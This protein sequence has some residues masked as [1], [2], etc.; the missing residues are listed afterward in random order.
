MIR[1]INSADWPTF[2]QRLS[3]ERAGAV[4]KLE[5]IEPGGAKSERA[6]AT[7]EKMAFEKNE[8]CNDVITL[9]L[10]EGREIVHQIVE[11][12]YIRLQPSSASDFNQIQIEAE[13]GVTLLTL[14]PAI[15][16]QMLEGFVS[17]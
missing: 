16:P 6:N 7:F 12:I 9:R 11:P 15:H 3:R 2:C 1:E 13:S 10:R 14:H 17:R 4:L 5:I 8:G